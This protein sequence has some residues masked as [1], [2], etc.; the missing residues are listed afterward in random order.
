MPFPRVKNLH[1][2][3]EHDPS[4]DYSRAPPFSHREPT[5]DV[6]VEDDK[7][8]FTMKQDYATEDAARNAVSAF[9]EAWEIEAGL[10]LGPNR[11]RLRFDYADVEDRNPNTGEVTLR[12]R[13]AKLPS[14][15]A[16]MKITVGETVYPAPPT[17]AVTLSPDVRSMYDRYLGFR[18][19]REPLPSI[20]YFCLTVLEMPWKSSK[21]ARRDA[22]SHYGIANAILNRV[23][24][25]SSTMGGRNARKAQGR[26]R[27]FS[28]EESRFL[29]RAVNAIV[30]RAAEVA[31]DP[32]ARVQRITMSDLPP[33]KP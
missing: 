19:G 7:V 22:A 11:F 9:I 27:N 3:V 5:F 26:Y 23:G 20:A 4:I 33:L 13:P 12:P 28:A 1:Y 32:S 24:T 8:C 21:N 10:K 15:T 30:R 2:V 17:I 31:H 6:S 18:Q 16:E 29:E 25:L 14:I